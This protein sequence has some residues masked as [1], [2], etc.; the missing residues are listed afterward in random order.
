MQGYYRQQSNWVMY[1]DNSQRI[2][3]YR[4]NISSHFVT[5]RFIILATYVNE[6]IWCVK[7]YCSRHV[8]R[9]GSTREYYSGDTLASWISTYWPLKVLFEVWYKV[10]VKL[11]FVINGWVILQLA[12]DEYHLILL[13]ISKHWFRKLAEPILTQIHVAEWR[14]KGTTS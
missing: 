14:H 9:N 4:K 5:S 6:N 3:N 13:T 2:Q 10:I 11:M 1:A 8:N 7:L 12:L